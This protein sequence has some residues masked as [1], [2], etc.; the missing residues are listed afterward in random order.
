MTDI[1]SSVLLENE[2]YTKF[3]EEE[4]WLSFYKKIDSN[5]FTF[6]DG[7]SLVRR[8]YVKMIGKNAELELRSEGGVR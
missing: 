6:D 7:S 5:A 2:T 8:T 1:Y 4:E 3:P